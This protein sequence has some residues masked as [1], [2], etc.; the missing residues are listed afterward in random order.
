MN[1]IN[2]LVIDAKEGVVEA[3]SKLASSVI[4]DAILQTTDG[5]NH[6]SIDNFMLYNVMKAVINGDNRPITNTCWSN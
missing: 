2:Q 6:R 4:T 5:S 1:V 3:V